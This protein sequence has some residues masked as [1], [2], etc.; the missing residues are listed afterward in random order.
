MKTRNEVLA[1]IAA[2]YLADGLRGVI[3]ATCGAN[4]GDA[5]YCWELAMNALYSPINLDKSYCDAQGR[6]TIEARAKFPG[7]DARMREAHER[8]TAYLGLHNY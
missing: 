5:V 8:L 2:A 4:H 1:P 7:V 3:D 6:P